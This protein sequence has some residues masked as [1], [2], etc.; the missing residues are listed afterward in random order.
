MDNSLSWFNP[1]YGSWTQ[2]GKV[3]IKV[4]NVHSVQ[5]PTELFAASAF[6]PRLGD[7]GNGLL[8]R[9]E[10]TMV[11]CSDDNICAGTRDDLLEFGLLG[12]GHVELVQ[13]LLEVVEESI[14]LGVS[15]L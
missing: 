13:G 15:N 4:C 11:W 6:S 1:R 3:E 9:G 7:T 12:L 10:P 8:N 5:K 2:R 14:P